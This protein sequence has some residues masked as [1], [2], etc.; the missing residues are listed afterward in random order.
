MKRVYN[1]TTSTPGNPTTSAMADVLDLPGA[2]AVANQPKRLRVDLQPYED[3]NDHGSGWLTKRRESDGLHAQIITNI[4]EQKNKIRMFIAFAKMPGA[5]CTNILEKYLALQ[6]AVN[7]FCIEELS[8]CVGFCTYDS[9]KE[10]D[11]QKQIAKLQQYAEAELLE[12]QKIATN[13]RPNLAN[14]MSSFQEYTSLLQRPDINQYAT[15]GNLRIVGGESS[16]QSATA[17]T[18][19]DTSMRAIQN[20]IETLLSLISQLETLSGEFV[21][22]VSGYQG[23]INEFCTSQLAPS[24][25]FIQEEEKQRE[26]R[27]KITTLQDQTTDML[28]KCAEKMGSQGTSLTDGLGQLAIGSTPTSSLG[29][30]SMS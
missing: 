4:N 29:D 2:G 9:E 8:K 24:V 21:S 18:F 20:N 1:S 17:T 11:A 10:L 22:Q 12:M 3:P 23:I 7:H 27:A 5:D 16:S 14:I 25:G 26:M 28:I 6:N 13:Q 15:G 30:D 19:I